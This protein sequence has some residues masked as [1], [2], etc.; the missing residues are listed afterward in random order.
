MDPFKPYEPKPKVVVPK[1]TPGDAET[2][3]LQ[4]VAWIVADDEMRDRFLA[5]TGCG[6]D[7]LRARLGQPGFLGCVLDFLLADEGSVLAFAE[8]FGLPPEMPIMARHKLP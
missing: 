2:I 5:V 1:L 4:I 6:G 3:A 8:H 7:D